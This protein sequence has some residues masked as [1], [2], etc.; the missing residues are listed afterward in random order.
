M[1]S[2]HVEAAL[3]A[4]EDRLVFALN[5]ADGRDAAGFARDALA[6]IEDYED[7]L[8][9]DD[10]GSGDPPP[11][12]PHRNVPVR[13]GRAEVIRAMSDYL[14][15]DE[16]LGVQGPLWR[17]AFD[18][19]GAFDHSRQAGLHKFFLVSLVDHARRQ[20]RSEQAP[21]ADASGQV[22]I[23]A[24]VGV[25]V[26]TSSL[27]IVVCD[28]A[29]DVVDRRREALPDEPGSVF[30][31]VVQTIATSVKGLV[32]DGDRFRWAD[33]APVLG[34]QVASA[35]RGPIGSRSWEQVPLD[36][37][38]EEATGLPT[39]VETGANAFAVKEQ[40]SGVGR[41]GDDFALVLFGET[42]GASVVQGGRVSAGP[43]ESSAW[44]ADMG[45]AAILEDIGGNGS[46]PV[47]HDL[48]EAVA[49]ARQEPTPDQDHDHEQMAKVALRAFENAGQTLGRWARHLIDR[50]G[51]PQLVVYGP[52]ALLDR[53][54]PAGRAFLDEL[55]KL[56]D[57][58]PDPS[59]AT[60][61]RSGPVYR[62]SRAYGAAHAAALVALRRFGGPVPPA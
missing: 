59:R 50:C 7:E 60:V 36:E 58:S 49:L 32:A 43:R 21:G 53:A 39:A 26:G 34:V 55:E 5:T 1:H 38:L 52:E 31:D 28:A 18:S 13:V 6:E 9:I 35:R 56:G 30:E 46:G 44:N 40:W 42:V 48:A 14:T 41:E 37:R 51:S 61:L 12:Q 29:G 62:P 27:E 16:R 57:G 20:E 24:A 23:A 25:A 54:E 8:S 17:R 4:A 2:P 22:A 33:E 15:S 19:V 47:V 3:S 45:G 11:P 10:R